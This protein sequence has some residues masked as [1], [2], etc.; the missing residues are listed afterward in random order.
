MTSAFRGGDLTSGIVDAVRQIA[1][2]AGRGAPLAIER[3][4]SELAPR[5]STGAH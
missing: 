3:A 1:D 4:G 2:S 5:D